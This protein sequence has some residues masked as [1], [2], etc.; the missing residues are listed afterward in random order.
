MPALSITAANVNVASTTVRLELVVGGEAITQGQPVYRNTSSKYLKTD[1]N[2]SLAASTAAGFALTRCTGD[3]ATF[4][5]MSG[6]NALFNLGATLVVGETYCVGR[7]PGEIVPIAD[8]TT[9]D[10]AFILGVAETTAFLKGIFSGS[11]VPK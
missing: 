8:L 2:A 5:M 3:N 11:S 7:T 4:V 6:V 9:G 10:Y 1:A